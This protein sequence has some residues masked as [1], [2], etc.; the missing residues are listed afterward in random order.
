MTIEAQA[1]D[2]TGVQCLDAANLI[3]FGITGD[4]TLVDNLGTSTGSRV[5]QLYNGRADI[6]IQTTGPSSVASV[7]S[8]GL[9][10]SFLN[11]ESKK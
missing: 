2:K 5:V 4:A 11:I 3:R 9:P 7:S 6:C 10:T 1:L 8:P